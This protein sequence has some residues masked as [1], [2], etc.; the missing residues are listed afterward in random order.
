MTRTIK[1]ISPL[2]RVQIKE[3]TRDDDDTLF[4]T[5]L[6]EVQAVGNLVGELSNFGWGEQQIGQ[7]MGRSLVGE[8]H[9]FGRGRDVDI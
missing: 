6:E 8:G 5:G 7:G 4:E 3:N 1:Q 9:K 2:T